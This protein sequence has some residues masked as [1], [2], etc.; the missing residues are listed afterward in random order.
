M[1]KALALFLCLFLVA[2]CTA[3]PKP[4]EHKNRNSENR[5]V[6][7]ADGG[8]IRIEIDRNLPEFITK[9]LSEE[10][11]L[12]L[13]RANIP[14][15]ADPN[16]A[17]KYLLK[18]F[19]K[20]KNKT[21]IKVLQS[22]KSNN[23]LL[24]KRILD[25]FKE[26]NIKFVDISSIFVNQG[27]GNFSGLRGSLA[28]AKGVSLAKNLNLFGYNT[29]IWSCAK[30]FNKTDTISCLIKFREKYFIKNFDKSLNS[31]SKVEKITEGEIKPAVIKIAEERKDVNTESAVNWR[32]NKFIN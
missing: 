13:A 22:D 12:A 2:D 15:S 10:A 25:F 6:A 18:G 27:P 8:T 7:L 26:N 1:T 5:L 14:A 3:L 19:V 16:F 32:D 20:I 4:F 30:F 29:F 31:L 21:F 28:I 23:D 11:I 17:S 24:M 9:P